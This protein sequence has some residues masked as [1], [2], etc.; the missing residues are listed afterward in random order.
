MQQLVS[1]GLWVGC[2]NRFYVL[3]DGEQDGSGSWNNWAGSRM[4]RNVDQDPPAP[5]NTCPCFPENTTEPSQIYLTATTL[6]FDN[7]RGIRTKTRQSSSSTLK[8]QHHY[9]HHQHQHQH[10]LLSYVWVWVGL[11]RRLGG[12]GL[13][14]RS[15][16]R[17]ASAAIGTEVKVELNTSQN[18]FSLSSRL[19]KN[20][21][22]WVW[23]P[24]FPRQWSSHGLGDS[25]N[26][27]ESRLVTSFLLCTRTHPTT[28]RQT[29]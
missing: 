19:L 28:I 13:T 20:Q 9:H 10:P 4:R 12:S 24:F 2:V 18:L 15:S 27:S 16:H 23:A 26:A 1:T 11:A 5:P 14:F 6:I 22:K 25:R 8:Q 17:N 3:Q 21:A 7:A 29:R